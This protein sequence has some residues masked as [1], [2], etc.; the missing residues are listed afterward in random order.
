M[1]RDAGSARVGFEEETGRDRH[2][3]STDPADIGHIRITH[4]LGAEEIDLCRMEIR[5]FEAWT[6]TCLFSVTGLSTASYGLRDG[7]QEGQRER[8]D[9]L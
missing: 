4:E 3:S 7:R 6:Q 9:G 8:T 1:Q 2:V 5:G